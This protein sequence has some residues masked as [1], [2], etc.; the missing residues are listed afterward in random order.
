MKINYCMWLFSRWFYFREFRKLDLT[1]NTTSI[2]HE[3]QP[4]QIS[5]PSP[6][7]KISVHENEGEYRYITTR[8]T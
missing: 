3:I 8:M 5:A 1:K 6:I 4:S 2:N 7:A